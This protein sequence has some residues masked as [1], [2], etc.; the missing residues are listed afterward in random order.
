MNKRSVGHTT[1]PTARTHLKFI[2]VICGLEKNVS[3]NPRFYFPPHFISCFEDLSTKVAP[4]WIWNG[5]GFGSINLDFS[6]FASFNKSI[7][8]KMLTRNSKSQFHSKFRRIQQFQKCPPL[9][10][11]RMGGGIWK[12]LGKSRESRDNLFL[13]EN[14]FLPRHAKDE[15]ALVNEYRNKNEQMKMHICASEF[16]GHS[17]SLKR[18]WKSCI[19]FSFCSKQTN[20]FV[21]RNTMEISEKR[22]HQKRS[23]L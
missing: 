9:I 5:L 11:I 18:R 20:C 14:N 22:P 2:H 15:M 8:N 6:G 23:N 12:N 16:D 1:R 3:T 13:S 10:C 21:A 7:F 19:L 4:I 17:E